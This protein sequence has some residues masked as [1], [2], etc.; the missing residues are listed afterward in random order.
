MTDWPTIDAQWP[1]RGPCAFCGCAD[2][3][4]RLFDS[5]RGN[6]RAGD[7]VERI[8]VAYDATV[9]AVNAVLAPKRCP[10]RRNVRA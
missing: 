5:M 8:A 3:R 10:L 6:F 9:E 2:A 4:H 1:Y 7:S